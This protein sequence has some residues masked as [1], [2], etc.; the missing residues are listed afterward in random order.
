MAK[1]AKRL[2]VTSRL[3]SGL[4]RGF[5]LLEVVVALMILAT[6]GLALFAWLSQNMQ[7][8]SRL[9]LVQR[10]A[11]LQLEGIEWLAT[12]NPALEPEGVRI[13]GELKLVWTSALLEAPRP[14]FD[15]GGAMVPRWQ[16]SLHR[17]AAKLEKLDS[18]LSVEWEQDLVGRRMLFGALRAE[19]KTPHVERAR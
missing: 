18:Q 12:I 19:A 3:P 9:E 13:K 17:I 4:V 11:Q 6:S 16:L 1:F 2:E 5:T 14:E 8:A 7:T 15:H 10:R